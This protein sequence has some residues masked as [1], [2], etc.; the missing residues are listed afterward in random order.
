MTF[1]LFL[2]HPRAERA[3]PA[4]REDGDECLSDYPRS[5]IAFR[6]WASNL[7]AEPC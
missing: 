4:F 5:A 2:R 7:L 3:K 1:V 6:F